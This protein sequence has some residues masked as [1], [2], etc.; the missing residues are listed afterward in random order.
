M[1]PIDKLY[2]L[3]T[4]PLFLVGT[5]IL[6]NTNANVSDQF[7]WLIGVALYVFIMF[8]IGNKYDEKQK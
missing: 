1:N 7:L 5:I 2:W 8:H 3:G 4:I 6:V